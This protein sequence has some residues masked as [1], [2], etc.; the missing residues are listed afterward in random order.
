MMQMD[1]D[2]KQIDVRIA[3][4]APIPIRVSAEDVPMVHFAEENVTQLW[5]K[6]SKLYGKEKSPLEIM[7]MVAFQF[8][9]RYYNDQAL[10]DETIELLQRFEGDLDSIILKTE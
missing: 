5:K 6:W 4:L 9:R 3:D 1:E 7:A 10:K 2:K 8:A